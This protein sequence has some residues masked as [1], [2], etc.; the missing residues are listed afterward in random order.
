MD[1]LTVWVLEDFTTGE[2]VDVHTPQG[3]M[4]GKRWEF[5]T[6]EQAVTAALNLD[7]RQPMPG[8]FVNNNRPTMSKPGVMK[9]K[10]I[11]L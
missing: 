3:V 9:V 7:Y 6:M 4:F 2:T 1:R 8:F 11:E 10:E 5:E